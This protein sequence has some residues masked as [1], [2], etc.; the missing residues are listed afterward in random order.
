M[1]SQAITD[2]I[3]VAV[4]APDTITRAGLLS[5]LQQANRLREIPLKK[6]D[7][8]DTIVVA[9]DTVDATALDL[10]PTL[11]DRPDARFVM[12]TGRE[13]HADISAAV[14]RGVRAVIWRDNFTPAAFIHT[15]HAI[16]D[17]GGSFPPTLQG[18]LMQQVQWTHREILAP[19]GLTAAGVTPREIDVLRLVADGKE[20]SEI[21]T[22][23]SY[24]ERT[25]KYV[26][27]G[28]MK[29]LHLRNR[30]HAVSYAIRAGLI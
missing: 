4:H 26:L 27:Y 21:A 23:L 29:R 10:L 3:R 7:E 16:A 30:A 1:T 14:D 25:V 24:S 18:T 2:T 20:L 9:V 6:I 11:N 28:L 17:G 19:R 15:L 12:I 8:A 13:W 5:C 22:K